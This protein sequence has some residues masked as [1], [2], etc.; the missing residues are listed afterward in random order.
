MA[1]EG[2]GEDLSTSSVGF[3]ADAFE[4]LFDDACGFGRNEITVAGTTK[5]KFSNAGANEYTVVAKR[6]EP[7]LSKKSTRNAAVP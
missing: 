5:N 3:L 6:I 2:A 1:S 4:E 7:T